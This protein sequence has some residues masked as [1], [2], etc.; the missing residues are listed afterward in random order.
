MHKA[1]IVAVREYKAAVYTKAFIIS[2]A[3]MP[4]MMG[5]GLLASYLLRGVKDLKERRFAVIDRT[6][7]AKLVA[8]LETKVETRNKNR[9]FDSKTGNQVEP[10]FAIE[11]VSPSETTD[12]A[13]LK[14][15][16]EICER[17]RKKELVGFMEIGKD[18]VTLPKLSL[19][20]IALSAIDS[21]SRVN[22]RDNDN[23]SEVKEA[24]AKIP[25]AY[26]VRYQTNNQLNQEFP[27]WALGV[28]NLAVL[29]F[30]AQ[31]AKLPPAKV[32]AL[33]RPLPLLNKELTTVNQT[34]GKAEEAKDANFLSTFLAPYFVMML[35]FMIVMLGAQPLL[36]GVIEEKT[37]RIA[38]VL[39]GSLSPFHLMAGKLMGVVAMSLTFAVVYLGGAYWAAHYFGY[40]KHIP[41]NLIGWFLLFQTLSVIMFGAVFIAAGAAC[42]DIKEAQTLMLPVML[43]LILPMMVFGNVI[44]DPDSKLAIGMS[45]FPPATPL[46]MCVRQSIPPGVPLWQ[47]GLGALLTLLTTAF[48]VWAAGRIFRIGLLAQGK[49]PSIKELVLWVVKG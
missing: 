3:V 13:I 12:D 45:L 29:E 20:A 22:A 9:A 43:V 47:M 7:G 1:L 8:I 33:A 23:S 2:L 37:Q 36:Q 6:E 4:L 28:L 10:T 5:G 17:I 31:D 24:M 16:L 42:N 14:Q 40:A 30:R 25:D 46:L 38:E 44:K 15:R 34:T 49:M 19:S 18:V 26:A 11:K 35:M 21:L 39:L 27:M 32:M 48:F 41:P